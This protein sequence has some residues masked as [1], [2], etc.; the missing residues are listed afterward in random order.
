MLFLGSDQGLLDQILLKE[1]R[2]WAIGSLGEECLK[3]G[4]GKCKVLGVLDGELKG[5][6]GDQGNLGKGPREESLGRGRGRA[7]QGL[8][9][10]TPSISF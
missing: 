9:L 2:K 5:Q 4:E 1:G 6:Q 7:L 8:G 10:H 3:Q